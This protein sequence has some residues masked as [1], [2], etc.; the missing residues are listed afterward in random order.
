M[1]KNPHFWGE[2]PTVDT[3]EFRVYSNQEAMVQALRSGEIDV[4]DGVRP[5]L[6]KTLDGI[7]GVTVQKVVSDW[8]LNLAFNFGGQG[9]DADPLPA[10]K[11]HDVRAAIAMAIDKQAIVAGYRTAT[12]R[13]DHPPAPAHGL[14]IPPTRSWQ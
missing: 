2:E 3:L 14:D 12:G 1:E 11:E 4:A 8:W 7:D 10:L 6:V 9:P 5:S 13:H